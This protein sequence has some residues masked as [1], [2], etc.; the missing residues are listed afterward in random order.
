M[1]RKYFPFLFGM[2]V[3]ILL[4]VMIYH[5]APALGQNES[6]HQLYFPLIYNPPEPPAWVGPYGGKIVSMAIARSQPWIIY[7]GTWDSGVF[8]STDSGATW[9]WKSAGLGNMYIQSI[10][11]D[12]KNPLVAYAGTYKGKLYKTVNGGESWFQSGANIQAEAIVYSIVIDPKDTNKIYIGTR[13]VSN[14]GGPPWNGVLYRSADAG[15]TWEAKL[16]DVGGKS[17]EDWVYSVTLHPNYPNQIYA[18]THE[19]GIYRSLNSAKNWEAAND[20]ITNFSTRAIVVNPNSSESKTVLYTGVWTYGGIFR[21][22][23]GGDSWNPQPNGSL[24]SQIYS[25]SINPIDSAIVYASTFTGGVLKTSSGGSSW[26]IVGLKDYEIA[27]TAIDPNTP[28]VLYSGTNGNGLYKSWDAGANWQHYQQGLHAVKATAIQVSPANSQQLYASLLVTGVEQSGDGGQN[29]SNLGSGLSKTNVFG[30]VI[31]PDQ[32]NIL[33][34]LTE[35]SGLYHCDLQGTCWQKITISFPL[36][37]QEAFGPEHPFWEQPFLEFEEETSDPFAV[38]ATPALLVMKFAPSNPQVAYLGTSGAGVYKSA[39]GGS[40]WTTAGLS[41]TKIVGLTVDAANPSRVFAASDTKVWSSDNGGGN[42]VDT[43]LSGIN[44][45]TL[46]FDRT[47]RL[48]AGTSNG[49]YQ[50]SGASWTQLGLAGLPVTVLA[51]HPTQADKLYAGTTNG[52]RISRNS[53]VNWDAGPTELNGVTVN[54]ISFDPEDASYLFVST[55][56]QGVLHMQDTQY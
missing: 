12:P 41:N 14:N 17:Q 27:A 49:V 23:N 45:Y 15:N 28:Q 2:I 50:R 20:G 56:T 18:A 34:A 1:I 10:A 42:W 11:V 29:W 37:A 52:L 21:S 31:P 4:A 5:P 35:S 13:G 6:T 26:S 44:I 30:L 3:L 33:F 32:P 40:S 16:T 22:N 47:G 53:G 7:A 39:N 9:T 19:H 54:G 43:G 55:T 36:T 24:D 38:S 25:M 8:K 46:A 51:P 48:L